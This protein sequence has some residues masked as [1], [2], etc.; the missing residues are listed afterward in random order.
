MISIKSGDIFTSN[1]KTLVVPT[2]CK[3]PMGAGLAAQFRDRFTGLEHRHKELCRLGHLSIGKLWM[4]HGDSEHTVMTF[5]TK[6]DWRNP[7]E[8]SYVAL[9]LAEFSRTYS[10]LGITSIAFPLLGTGL[11]GLPKAVVMQLMEAHLSELPINI[12]IWV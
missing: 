7:S 10:D 1:C 4:W 11:G 5:P 12:E 8:L 9:G 2:N 6:N 3:G